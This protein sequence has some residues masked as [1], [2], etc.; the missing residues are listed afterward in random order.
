M[1]EGAQAKKRLGSFA[2]DFR[3]TRKKERVS[4]SLRRLQNVVTGVKECWTM[5]SYAEERTVK[6]IKLDTVCSR[7]VVTS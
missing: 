6:D 3:H 2:E 5:D 7:T 4:Q 1:G